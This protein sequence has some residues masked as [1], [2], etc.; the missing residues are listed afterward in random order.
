[1]TYSHGPLKFARRVVELIGSGVMLQKVP[2]R[3]SEVPY[4]TNLNEFNGDFTYTPSE[5]ADELNR[6]EI[7]N[8]DRFHTGLGEFVLWQTLEA[9]DVIFL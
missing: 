3:Q 7:H 2:A 8:Q 5:R 6:R 1:M 9:H 4:V